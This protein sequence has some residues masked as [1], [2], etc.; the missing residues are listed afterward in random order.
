M[1]LLKATTTLIF[2]IAS[3][4]A[5]VCAQQP[6]ANKAPAANA[7]VQNNDGM[8]LRPRTYF[9][10]LMTG[11]WNLSGELGVDQDY[12]D[13][14]LSS[15]INRTSDL[16]THPVLRIGLAVQKKRLSAQFSYSPSFSV[17]SK[18]S[19]RNSLSQSFSQSLGYKWSAH[20]DLGWVLSAS[21]QSTNSATNSELVDFGGT[22]VPVFQ[23]LELQSNTIT[24][25]LASI[26]SYSHALSAQNSISASLN[27]AFTYIES[28][29][30]SLWRLHWRTR[31]LPAAR[32]CHGTISLFPEDL[33]A[34]RRAKVISHFSIRHRTAI[35][36]TRSCD[37]RRASGMDLIFLSAQA[38]ATPPARHE[39]CRRP[40]P[41]SSVMRLM[42]RSLARAGR[43]PWA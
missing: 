31:A 13:N 17:Y 1:R 15:A 40:I 10:E 9:G 28:D 30:G 34:Y 36:N 14:I 12:D 38:R 20:T 3:L 19:D 8:D 43:A 42:Y 2:T 21:R 29:N 25:G 22:F 39:L 23:P 37:T 32:A 26:M 5:F 41:A 35:M 11:K 18:Y 7:S 16:V 24:T 27:T 4:S 6:D 33:S